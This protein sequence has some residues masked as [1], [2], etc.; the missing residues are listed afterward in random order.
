MERPLREYTVKSAFLSNPPITVS[1]QSSI[2]AFD[3][4]K[5][6]FQFVGKRETLQITRIVPSD[7]GLCG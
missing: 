5:Y 3:K 4:A 2:E 1:A 7:Y 6:V